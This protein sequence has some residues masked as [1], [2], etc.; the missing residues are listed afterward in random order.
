MAYSVPTS[1]EIQASRRPR[2]PV[3]YDFREAKEVHVELQENEVHV[4]PQQLV[5]T[6][7]DSELHEIAKPD[8][9]ERRMER[10][11]GVKA[12]DLKTQVSADSNP[13]KQSNSRKRLSSSVSSNQQKGLCAAAYRWCA[14]AYRH[15]VAACGPCSKAFMMMKIVVGLFDTKPKTNLIQIQSKEKS[16]WVAFSDYATY[17]A[18]LC[19]EQTHAQALSAVAKTG[20]FTLAQAMESEYRKFA[21]DFWKPHEILQ[22]QRQ[23]FRAFVVFMLQKLFNISVQASLAGISANLS[24]ANGAHNGADK[25][26]V[27]TVLLSCCLGVASICTEI[28][29]SRSMKNMVLKGVDKR[30]KAEGA[31]KWIIH[32][33][34]VISRTT[35]QSWMLTILFSLWC[36]TFLLWCAVKTLMSWYCQCG[37]WNF[38]RNMFFPS[39]WGHQIEM[40]CVS[41]GHHNGTDSLG[42]RFS[43][44]HVVQHFM[45]KHV[46][47]IDVQGTCA[48]F[49]LGR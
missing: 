43:D 34:N 29:S 33:E 39:S 36:L 38:T 26:T 25:L 4:E 22:V 28:L 11:Y 49:W 40:G 41:F 35:R 30:V 13:N 20:R 15:Y 19:D 3:A 6:S 46:N 8:E 42:C 23:Q 32:H 45:P 14:R 9:V 21:M 37:M 48:C 17:T 2:Q 16:E 10:R 1:Q 12:K 7:G 47:F 44:D 24:V 18:L 31:T 27:V 5:F